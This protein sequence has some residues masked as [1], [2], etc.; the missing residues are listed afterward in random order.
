MN[1]IILDEA[2]N[3]LLDA[4]DFYENKSFGLGLKLKDEIDKYV[5]WI[6]QNYDSP[7]LRKGLYR[8]VNLNIFPYYVLKIVARFKAACYRSKVNFCVTSYF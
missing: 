2:H 7:R 4:I 5:K 6:T 3:E 1:I 8:R